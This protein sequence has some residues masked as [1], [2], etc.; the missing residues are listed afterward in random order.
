MASPLR[1]VGNCTASN[2]QEGTVD[3]SPAARLPSDDKGAGRT[4][5]ST[6]VDDGLGTAIV[7][8][9]EN[10]LLVTTCNGHGEID[11]EDENLHPHVKELVNK[12]NKEM[13]ANVRRMCEICNCT[14]KEHQCAFG[15]KTRWDSTDGKPHRPPYKEI[16]G[17]SHVGSVTSPGSSQEDC[18]LIVAQRPQDINS[19]EWPPNLSIFRLNRQSLLSRQVLEINA[20]LV[21]LEN[22]AI[23][24]EELQ[25]A[26]TALYLKKKDEF[27][28]LISSIGGFDAL[29][30]DRAPNYSQEDYAHFAEFAVWV[31]QDPKILSKMPRE[32]ALENLW[33]RAQNLKQFVVVSKNEYDRLRLRSHD[34]KSS[35]LYRPDPGKNWTLYA[36]SLQD[37]SPGAPL[38]R[39]KPWYLCNNNVDLDV[40]RDELGLYSECEFCQLDRSLHQSEFEMDRMFKYSRRWPNCPTRLP[41][42]G[43]EALEELGPVG[44]RKALEEHCR[45]N[46]IEQSLSSD[47]ESESSNTGNSFIFFKSVPP[48]DKGKYFPF[49]PDYI[50][51]DS[52]SDDCGGPPYWSTNKIKEAHVRIFNQEAEASSIEEQLA[53]DIESYMAAMMKMRK[54]CDSAGTCPGNREATAPH[55]VRFRNFGSYQTVEAVLQAWELHKRS[56]FCDCFQRLEYLKKFQ[57]VAKQDLERLCTGTHDGKSS[58][59]F[60]PENIHMLEPLDPEKPWYLPKP[61]M[62][63][64]MSLESIYAEESADCLFCQ[65]HHR[66]CLLEAQMELLAKYCRRW[67]DSDAVPRGFLTAGISVESDPTNNPGCAK[68]PR[69]FSP[70]SPKSPT[71]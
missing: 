28:D 57:L 18:E 62:L 50:H 64:A 33:E 25:E 8:L 10:G 32:R 29:A 3:V 40:S 15:N 65:L 26:D 61:E 31:T 38:D 30:F 11:W 27:F 63:D 71:Y 21:C 69:L 66:L 36:G 6:R 5:D 24:L 58:L 70:P 55:L 7:G 59:Y 41:L 52:S 37:K 68:K 17:G 39:H 42:G 53:V 14:Q 46:G 45:L 60:I 2:G 20:R 49:G 13:E 56:L 35:R 44:C 34:G 16:H 67:P 4:D 51:V 12:W 9:T 48:E 1:E 54:D 23:D 47:S 43:R 22:R 19:G